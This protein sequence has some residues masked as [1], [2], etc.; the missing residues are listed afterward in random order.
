MSKVK[1]ACAIGN[2]AENPDLLWWETR[3][4][5][6]KVLSPGHLDA[7]DDDGIVVIT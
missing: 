6:M 7:I 3:I 4:G 1:T 5:Y 2:R